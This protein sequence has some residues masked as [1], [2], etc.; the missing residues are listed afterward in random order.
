MNKYYCRCEEK[1]MKTRAFAPGIAFESDCIY[2]A[3][4]EVYDIYPDDTE[5]ISHYW[6]STRGDAPRAA[7]ILRGLKNVTIDLGGAK[8]MFHGRILPFA[9]YNCENVSFKNFSIDYD[10]PFYTQGTI[11]EAAPGE[12]VIDIPE[13]FGYRVEDS[14]FIATSDTWEHKVNRG[15]ILA[16]VYD[17]N[18]GRIDGSVPTFLGLIGDEIFPGENP[19]LPIHHLRAYALEGRRVR[20]TGCPEWFRPRAG[21]IFVFTH[22][23]RAKAGFIAEE[24]AELEFENIRLLHISAMAFMA[25]LCRDLTFRN[26]SCYIDRQCAGRMISVNAD[27]IHG[28]HCEGRVLVEDCRFENMLDDSFNIHGNYTACAELRDAR[29]MVVE[30]KGHGLRDMKYYLPGDKINIYRGSTQEL[31]GVYTIESAEYLPDSK[32][33][34]L[35][36]TAEDITDFAVGDIVESQRMPEI[37]IRRCVSSKARG[38]MR[39]SSGRRM[40]I[41]DCVFEKSMIMFTGDTDYWYENAPVRDV[42]IRNCRFENF[43]EL[44]VIIA[45]PHFEATMKAPYYYKN[46]RILDN[47]FENCGRSIASLRSVDGVEIKGNRVYDENGAELPGGRVTLEECRGVRID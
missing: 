5:Q 8:L 41:E 17:E 27:I 22:E 37:E 47:V 38:H 46:V 24:S 45:S 20:L 23:D 7:F 25:N 2:T 11:V 31:K 30:N 16:Q 6:W 43:P 3:D 26:F 40:L 32:T 4:R 18:T 14:Y 28:F 44:D 29:T 1:T 42:T 10:R 36:K 34:Q 13:Q 21:E 19:P 9:I 15:D 33:L 35:L 12:I 39:L